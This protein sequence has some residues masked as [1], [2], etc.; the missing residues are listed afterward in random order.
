LQFKHL[1]LKRGQT[2]LFNIYNQEC[3]ITLLQGLIEITHHE[4]K[5]VLGP[6]R[7]V[8]TGASHS[9]YC[10]GRGDVIIRAVT[11]SEIIIAALPSKKRQ[12]SRLIKPRD[13]RKR[14]VGKGDYFRIVHDIVKEE[15]PGGCLLA[16]ETFNRPGKWSSFPPHK[17]DRDRLPYESKL[18]EVYFF[19]VNPANRFGMI[20]LYGVFHGKYHDEAFVIQNNDCVIIPFGYH[21]VCAAPATQLYYFWVLAGGKRKLRCSV[22]GNYL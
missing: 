9:F 3:L 22:D 11:M 13:I 12:L 8:F 17:H 18:E 10:I 5:Y 14:K 6:R 2:F 16:G 20:R 21:P 19:K 7:S 15:D 1:S 4:E